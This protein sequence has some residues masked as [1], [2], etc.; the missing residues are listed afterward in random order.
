M[1]AI[2]WASTVATGSN[3][4]WYD[5]IHIVHPRLHVSKSWVEAMKVFPVIFV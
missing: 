4:Y 3:P 2:L 5:Q 1:A